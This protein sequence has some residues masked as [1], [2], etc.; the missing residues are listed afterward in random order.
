MPQY[1]YSTVVVLLTSRLR[2]LIATHEY[3]PD[4]ETPIDFLTVSCINLTGWPGIFDISIWRKM[5]TKIKHF[6]II[7]NKW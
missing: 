1:A 3:C 4:L 7:K 6:S 5:Q 2:V